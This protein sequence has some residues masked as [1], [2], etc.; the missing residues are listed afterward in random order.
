MIYKS[1]S[2]EDVIGRVL[3][4]TRVQDSSYITDMG[5]WIPEAMDYMK[6]RVSLQLLWKDVE[7]DFYKGKLPC[8]LRT[9]RAVSHNNCRL[10]PYEG[11]K[12][13]SAGRERDEDRTLMFVSAPVGPITTT[14][15]GTLTE[16]DYVWTIPTDNTIGFIYLIVSMVINGTTTSVNVSVNTSTTPNINSTI[17]A[18]QTALNALGKGTFTVTF[19]LSNNIVISTLANTNILGQIQEAT[20]KFSPSGAPFNYYSPSVTTNTVPIGVDTLLESNVPYIPAQTFNIE[21]VMSLPYSDET[22]YTE[23]DWINTSFK[24]GKVRLYYM[25][26]PV[27][28]NGFPLVPDNGNYKEA[29]Y[30]YVRSRMIGAGYKDTVFK[31]QECEQKF[32]LHAARAMGQIRY[33]SVDQAETRMQQGSRLIMDMNYFDTFFSNPGNESYTQML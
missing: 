33:P 20:T 12:A 15:S 16:Y 25:A 5:E 11:V 4:N 27:D 28:A 32:E 18:L 9:L 10:R 31:Y 17:A 26:I 30:W 13:A 14:H 22:Y 29:I 23:L 24:C 7:I 1:T 2:I 3:R 8:G 21:T 6:T 19:D